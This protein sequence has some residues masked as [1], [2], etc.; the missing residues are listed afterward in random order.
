MPRLCY[1]AEDKEAGMFAIDTQPETV[2]GAG[3]CM[4]FYQNTLRFRSQLPRH[5]VGRAVALEEDHA[6][7]VEERKSS[8]ELQEIVPG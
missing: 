3:V 8:R 2:K 7:C 6:K 5:E 4:Q 1:E